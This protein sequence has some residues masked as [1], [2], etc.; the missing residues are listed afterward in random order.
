MT[1]LYQ[2]DVTAAAT[3]APLAA[4]KVAPL[5]AEKVTF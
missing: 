3:V 1:S 4:K 5:A 2:A